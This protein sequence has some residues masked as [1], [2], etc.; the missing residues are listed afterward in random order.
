MTPLFPAQRAAEEFERVLSGTADDAVAARYA[1]LRDAVEQLRTLPEVTPR[2]EFVGDLVD[3]EPDVV[4][5]T[6]AR[7]THAALFGS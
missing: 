7:V 2:A 3:I 6:L 1:E 4:A 5:E